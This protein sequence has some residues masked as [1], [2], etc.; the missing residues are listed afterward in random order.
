M[1]WKYEAQRKMILSKLYGIYVTI[2][3]LKE[4][5]WDLN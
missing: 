4:T 5:I 2:K 1:F 3:R